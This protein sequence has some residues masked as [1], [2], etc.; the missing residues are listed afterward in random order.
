MAEMSP[1][2]QHRPLM[3]HLAYHLLGSMSEAE[4][5]Y[6]EV[7]TQW[8]HQP[9]V[10]VQNPKALLRRMTVNRSLDR[11]R[12]VK[13][14]REAYIGPWLPEPVEHPVWQAEL[15]T[16]SD[17]L[18][19][20]LEQLNPYERAV[21]L[22]RACFDWEYEAIAELIEKTESNCRQLLRRARKKLQ[23]QDW[24]YAPAPTQITQL[25]S[26]FQSASQESDFGPLRSLLRQD[27]QLYSDGG[28][29]VKAALKPILGTENCLKFLEGVQRFLSPA[30]RFTLQPLNGQLALWTWEGRQ[31]MGTLSFQW[32]AEGISHIC[33]QRNP[34]KLETLLPQD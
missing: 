14:E 8:W 18:L 16:L 20:V 34:D 31:L 21:Y 30:T 5:I 7:A 26:A 3:L 1:T 32:T 12:Q 33:S 25:L 28:G 13:R 19:M 27:V 11:L 29:K 4:D 9:P 10:A 6:Q 17:A 24:Q 15:P 22:L 23:D 2:E